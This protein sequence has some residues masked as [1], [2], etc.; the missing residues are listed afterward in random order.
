M[1]KSGELDQYDLA[2][3]HELTQDSRTPIQELGSRIGLSSTP[4]WNRIKALEA[5]GVIQGFGIRVDPAK[6]G[7]LETVIVQVILENHTEATHAAFQQS[8]Q[9]VP[10]ITEAYLITGD[11]DY[12]LK[13]VARSISDFEYLLRDKLLKLPGIRQ[14]KSSFVLR[15][16]KEA[17]LPIRPGPPG[18]GYSRR[19]P[20]SGSHV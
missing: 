17:E 6:L 12:L 4:C 16:L 1:N 11:N 18:P 10:A 9:S 14:T 15:K 8:L 19:P 7:F 20:D 13:I 5:A 3:L 2:I